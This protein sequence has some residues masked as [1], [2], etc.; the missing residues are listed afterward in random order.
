MCDYAR[1]QYK[2]LL[3]RLVNE[4]LQETILEEPGVWTIPAKSCPWTFMDAT[5]TKVNRSPHSLREQLD[6]LDA[7]EPARAQWNSCLLDADRIKHLPDALRAMFRQRRNLP[8]FEISNAQVG[9][10]ESVTQAPESHIILHVSIL[11]L[12][13]ASTINA[14]SSTFPLVPLGYAAIAILDGGM[15]S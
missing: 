13:L 8:Q 7:R 10:S 1:K 11:T 15:E 4:G 3:D 6:I 2:V 5:H 14:T 9:A 12:H